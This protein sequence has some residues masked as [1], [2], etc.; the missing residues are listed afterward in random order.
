[1][2]SIK[3]YQCVIMSFCDKGDDHTRY[4]ELIL[5]QL[6][7]ATFITVYRKRIGTTNGNLNFDVRV[8]EQTNDHSF[9]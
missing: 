5:Q 3:K 2:I 9:L 4:N 7:A 8:N 6:L 1:M